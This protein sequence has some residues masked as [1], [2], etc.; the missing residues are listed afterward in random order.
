MSTFFD[1]SCKKDLLLAATSGAARKAAVE[2][3]VRLVV[4]I[5][6]RVLV[7]FSSLTVRFAIGE[8]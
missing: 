7:F 5:L 4:R 8:D 2:E 3:V 6:P 1:L